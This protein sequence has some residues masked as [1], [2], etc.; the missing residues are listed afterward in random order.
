MNRRVRHS[1]RKISAELL[2]PHIPGVPP[3]LGILGVQRR[4]SPKEAQHLPTREDP[5]MF[6]LE[7]RQA[8]ATAARIANSES[9]RPALS[10][11]GVVLGSAFPPE[12]V[13]VIPLRDWSLNPPP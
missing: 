3:I 2:E 9:F 1:G 8:S 10:P 11:I 5:S 7:N 13:G 6:P 12:T 4:L